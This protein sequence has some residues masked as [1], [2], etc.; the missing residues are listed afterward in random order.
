MA[1]YPARTGG[2][3][4]RQVHQSGEGDKRPAGKAVYGE[5]AARGAVDFEDAGQHA[6]DGQR[7]QPRRQQPAAQPPGDD[8]HGAERA[9]RQRQRAAEQRVHKGKYHGGRPD[10]MGKHLIDAAEHGDKRG[11]AQPH[12]RGAAQGVSL[13][14]GIR[15]RQ[16]RSRPFPQRSCRRW[17][18]G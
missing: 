7:G 17:S 5:Q 13:L 10:V 2:K 1:A 6:A 4:A 14:S 3:K 11:G 9:D 8:P 12:E 16:C 15:C 18:D